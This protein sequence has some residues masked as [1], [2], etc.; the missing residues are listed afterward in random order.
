[1]NTTEQLT[2]R[3]WLLQNKLNP[4]P[5]A[6]DLSWDGSELSLQLGAAAAEAFS[7]WIAKRLNGDVDVLKEQLKG[8]ATMQVFRCQ[9]NDF[10]VNWPKTF[11]GSAMEVETGGESWLICM[12][13]PSGGAIMQTINLMQGRK[14]AKPWKQALS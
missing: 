4:F 5:V 2:Q 13:Y 8:G 3:V 11:A 6:A 10:T 12:E 14:K 9:R 7:G 1:M